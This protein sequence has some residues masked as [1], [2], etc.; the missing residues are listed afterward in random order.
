MLRCQLLRDE[1]HAT[2]PAGFSANNPDIDVAAI[3]ESLPLLNGVCNEGLRVFPSVPV[4]IR[5]TK[6]QSSEWM[7]ENPPSMD[8]HPTWMD[9]DGSF[10][11]HPWIWIECPD[12][13]GHPWIFC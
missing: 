7:D 1:I 5:T 2:L 4:T 3:L 6:H 8:I 11:V 12:I 13:H 10:E 9:M